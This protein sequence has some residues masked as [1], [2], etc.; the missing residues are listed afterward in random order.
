MSSSTFSQL[1]PHLDMIFLAGFNGGVV[2]QTLHLG[3][4]GS[5]C[6]L[7]LRC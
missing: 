6:P 7:F 4:P 3:M 2:D 5:D 1:C